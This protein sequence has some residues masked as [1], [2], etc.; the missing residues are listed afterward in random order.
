MRIA[1][2]IAPTPVCTSLY[3][4]L[5]ETDRNSGIVRILIF[6]SMGLGVLLIVIAAIMNETKGAEVSASDIVNQVDQAAAKNLA[7]V[8]IKLVVPS[9]RPAQE[10]Q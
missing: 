5:P 8:G 3:L 10:S 2:F 7:D 1:I 4:S 9:S 6:G